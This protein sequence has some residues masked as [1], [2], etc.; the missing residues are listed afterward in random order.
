[1]RAR[2]ATERGG[3]NAVENL[4]VKFMRELGGS[5]ACAAIWF[6]LPGIMTTLERLGSLGSYVEDD[7]TL[8]KQFHAPHYLSGCTLRRSAFQFARMDSEQAPKIV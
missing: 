6:R 3:Q 7:V 1:M 4:A 2:R 5:F 8:H